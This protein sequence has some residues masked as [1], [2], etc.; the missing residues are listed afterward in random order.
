MVFRRG[1]FSPPLTLLMSAFALLI[2]P[3]DLAIHLHYSLHSFPTRRS[4][5]LFPSHDKRT[6]SLIESSC[7][8]D[9]TGLSQLPKLRVHSNV[10]GR[11]A[12]CKPRRWIVRSAGGI[13]SA[14]ADM[15]SVKGGEK[16]PRRKRAYRDWETD[17]KSTRLNS[18]HS[19]ES[20]MPS[21]A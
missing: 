15:S 7:A 6:S 11:R 16:P 21:S 10:R 5:D 1:G 3:A 2:P 4:S 19:G 13:R 17:R 18:S 14:N 8:E 9:V 12:F 20:R